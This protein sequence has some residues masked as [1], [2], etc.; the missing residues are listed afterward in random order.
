V[1]RVT[2]GDVDTFMV[3]DWRRRIFGLYSVIRSIREP[4]EAHATWVASRDAMLRGHPASPVPVEARASYPGADVAPYDPAYRFVLPVDR[5]V[6]PEHLDIATATDGVVPFDR[7]GRVTLPDL[8][9]LDVWW[10]G[11][12]GG[13]IFLP[14]RDASPDTYG[15]GR[16]LLDTVKGADLGGDPDA[17]VVDLNF[18]YQP[19]CAYDD[20][21]TCPLA[22]PGNTLKVELPVGERYRPIG[23]AAGDGAA[24]TR[25]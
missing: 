17:L 23:P 18:C 15:G 20:I 2:T 24:S 8:G 19:S 6:E 1:A 12:Y 10:L 16:Y 14:V 3:L 4:E 9:E 5:D 21:W 11:S 13:G 22:G 7:V 25:R